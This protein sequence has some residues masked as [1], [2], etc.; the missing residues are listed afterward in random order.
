MRRRKCEKNDENV[1]FAAKELQPVRKN[2]HRVTTSRRRAVKYQWSPLGSPTVVVRSRLS[3]IVIVVV[4]VIIIIV[5]QTPNVRRNRARAKWENSAGHVISRRALARA[6][7]VYILCVTL[8]S[9]P[10][11]AA[12]SRVTL[13]ARQSEVC[14][15]HAVRHP[16]H[17]RAMEVS[18][19]EMS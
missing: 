17:A 4:V 13:L 9:Y 1:A 11:L 12:P 5:A 16:R 18:Q 8:S 7:A 19:L 15:V 6:V 14:K 2:P 10:G 3:I